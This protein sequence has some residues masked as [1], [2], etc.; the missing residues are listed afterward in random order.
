MTELTV[1][2][3][4][5]LVA[6]VD[7]WKVALLNNAV[8]ADVYRAANGAKLDSAA[9]EEKYE[10]LNKER[11]EPAI[12]LKAKLVVMKHEVIDNAVKQILKEA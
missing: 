2:E 1:E 3:F 12:M 7:A 5:V 9:M 10:E 8:M 6:A 4:D 11:T